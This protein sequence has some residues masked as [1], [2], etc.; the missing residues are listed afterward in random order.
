M[1]YKLPTNTHRE[2]EEV[3]DELIERYFIDGEYESIC[4]HTSGLIN[5][6]TEEQTKEFLE[7]LKEHLEMLKGD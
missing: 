3:S 2:L 7:M 4:A 1:T 5:K 6:L